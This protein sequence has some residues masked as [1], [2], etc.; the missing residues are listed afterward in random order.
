MNWRQGW[1]FF[2][3]FFVEITRISG[4]V[5]K[6][7]V[8]SKQLDHRLGWN[9]NNSREVWWWDTLVHNIIEVD[10][11]EERMPF[12]LFRISFPGSKTTIWISC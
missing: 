8:V 2:R 12:N 7:R 9:T 3:E 11:F 5:L 1:L 10:I 4:T 6:Q